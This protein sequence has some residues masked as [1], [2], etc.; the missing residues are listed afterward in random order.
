[1]NKGDSR[2]ESASTGHKMPSIRRRNTKKTCGAYG[3][4]NRAAEY[5]RNRTLLG[6]FQFKVEHGADEVG[7][8]SIALRGLGD[9]IK[10]RLRVRFGAMGRGIGCG[11]IGAARELGKVT[12]VVMG[13][14]SMGFLRRVEVWDVIKLAVET[15]LVG[16]SVRLGRLKDLRG[17]QTSFA[18]AVVV[19]EFGTLRRG[20]LPIARV[21]D[22]VGFLPSFVDDTAAFV[23]VLLLT[24][25][26]AFAFK[27]AVE[28]GDGGF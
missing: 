23:A 8:L 22:L 2:T 9:G 21:L 28:F 11:T 7:E 13:I 20:L 4:S 18:P 1:M 12:F 14:K 10:G 15:L 27:C 5:R 16:E 19:G 25:D 6:G 3:Q 26:D 17:P 24:I